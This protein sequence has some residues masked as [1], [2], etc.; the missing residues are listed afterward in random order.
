MI[1]DFKDRYVLEEGYP[2]AIGIR[3]Y[4]MIT[5]RDVPIG[6]VDKSLKWPAELWDKNVPK[7]KLVLEK[8][9]DDDD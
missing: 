1:V 3:S 5:L 2:W 6:G 9:D 7:Y 8:I 4:K